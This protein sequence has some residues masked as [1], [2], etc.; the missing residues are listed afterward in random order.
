MKVKSLIPISTF[1]LITC[2]ASPALPSG[3]TE[4]SAME[5]AVINDQQWQ[6]YYMGIFGGRLAFTSAGLDVTGEEFGGSTA[7]ASESLSGTGPI[8]GLK[9]GYNFQ[10]G[11]WVYGAELSVGRFNERKL[12]LVN[13]DDGLYVEIDDVI[14]NAVGRIG[15]TFGSSLIFG[16]L[17]I[18]HSNITNAGGEYD[19]V[20]REDDRG[21]LGFDGNEAGIGDSSRTGYSIG[22]GFEQFLSEKLSLGL[23][24]S[25]IEFSDVRYD[26][27]AAQRRGVEDEPFE[28]S[29]SF[30]TVKVSLNYRF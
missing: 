20:G 27:L 11:R 23:E 7:G 22:V 28:F 10:N 2:L 15:Y 4:A 25:I 9:L 6:G 29:D 14:V 19:G 5:P 16:T 13:R 26:N 17:G 12:H 24:Y 30:D 8:A 18:A 3:I 1:L 21:R